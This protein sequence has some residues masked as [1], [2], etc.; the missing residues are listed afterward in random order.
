MMRQHTSST[1]GAAVHL[2]RPRTL[3]VSASILTA[4]CWSALPAAQSPQRPA[5]QVPTLPSAHA[6]GTYTADPETLEKPKRNDQVVFRYCDG[7]GNAGDA[8]NPNGAM[9]NIAGIVSEGGNVLGMMPHPERAC[10]AEL[11]GTDGRPL[12][13]S[14]LEGFLVR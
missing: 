5:A 9:E 12:F 6:E 3:I 2:H 14:L 13:E 8:A 11:G 7:S 1:A 10:E 4:L